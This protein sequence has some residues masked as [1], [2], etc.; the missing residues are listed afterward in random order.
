MAE[1]EPGGPILAAQRRPADDPL[2]AVIHPDLVPA[3]DLAPL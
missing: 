3:D 2:H 1:V